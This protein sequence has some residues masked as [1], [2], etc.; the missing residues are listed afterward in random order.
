MAPS[1]ALDDL[2]VAMDD[3]AGLLPVS[4]TD[5][6][7]FDSEDRDGIRPG[8]SHAMLTND[9]WSPIADA[10]VRGRSTR[11]LTCL[12]SCASYDISFPS[13]ALI[14]LSAQ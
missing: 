11:Q 6:K 5:T 7:G 1:A 12:I 10:A 3:M 14:H 13:S 4:I 9:E 2:C 8:M